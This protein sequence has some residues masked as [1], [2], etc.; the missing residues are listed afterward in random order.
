MDKVILKLEKRKELLDDLIK[1]EIEREEL[2]SSLFPGYAY[3]DKKEI[4]NK[5]E[6]QFFKDLEQDIQKAY[7]KDLIKAMS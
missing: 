5:I 3:S 7:T 4:G 2:I 1:I 6:E